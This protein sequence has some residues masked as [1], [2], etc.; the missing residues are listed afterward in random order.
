MLKKLSSIIQ[1]DFNL[2]VFYFKG[3][4][5]KLDS[6]SAMFSHSL[7]QKLSLAR[8]LARNPK[9]LV[10]D[11]IVESDDPVHELAMKTAIR[12]CSQGRTIILFSQNVV[13]RFLKIWHISIPQHVMYCLGIHSPS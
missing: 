11:N 7:K 1:L 9:I 13:R 4:E 2:R 6:H 8:A 5:T 12:D 10:V 3:Y